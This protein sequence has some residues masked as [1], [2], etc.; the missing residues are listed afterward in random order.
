ML[1]NIAEF[2]FF[3]GLIPDFLYPFMLQWVCCSHFMATV[4]NVAMNISVKTSPWGPDFWGINIQQDCWLMGKFS[5]NFAVFL[6]SPFFHSRCTI[7][8]S[9]H[10]CTRVS[11]FPHSCQHLSF[12]LFSIYVMAII[13]NKMVLVS[14]KFWFVVLWW[15][16]IYIFLYLLLIF[17]SSFL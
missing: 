16:V 8:L 17:I 15:L 2:P 12:F 6:K 5:I 14:L 1:L 4:D 9:H 7:L 3:N 11:I 13:T 10:Q